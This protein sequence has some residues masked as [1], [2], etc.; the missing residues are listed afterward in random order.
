VFGKGVHSLF[1]D[2]SQDK[3]YWFYLLTIISNSGKVNYQIWIKVGTEYA[4]YG[5]DVKCSRY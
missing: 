2:F 5:L 3:R 1:Y 4:N